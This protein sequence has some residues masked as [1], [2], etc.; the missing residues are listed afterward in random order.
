MYA[1]PLVTFNRFDMDMNNKLLENLERMQAQGGGYGMGGYYMDNY[2]TE[3]RAVDYGYY[4][5]DYYGTM[6]QNPQTALGFGLH[7]TDP[8]G[9]SSYV[10]LAQNFAES[11]VSARAM[12]YSDAVQNLWGSY[13]KL[14]V[15]GLDLDALKSSDILQLF[16]GNSWYT[17]MG[18]LKVGLRYSDVRSIANYE[19]MGIYDLF[20][21][22]ERTIL[23]LYVEEHVDVHGR[24][25]HVAEAWAG[26]FVVGHSYLA[27]SH[28]EGY[29]VGLGLML[30]MLRDEGRSYTLSFK[31]GIS[32]NYL[33][34]LYT[35]PIYD[36]VIQS[37]S[38][39]MSGTW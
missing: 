13:V 11:G 4:N 28:I 30:P 27:E 2:L 24:L 21:V 12:L 22:D 20:Y 5:V 31:Y 19:I 23:R 39:S 8:M 32:E 25:K 36:A 34:T 38:L 14:N 35:F 33:P 6:P 17:S 15:W 10:A 1:Q 18:D 29:F 37:M 26:G 7:L 16:L 9:V 3:N